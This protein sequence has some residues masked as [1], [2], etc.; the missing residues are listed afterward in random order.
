MTGS[1]NKKAI[2]TKYSHFE[3]VGRLHRFAQD[4]FTVSH[5]IQQGTDR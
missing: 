4:V 2:Y 1:L 3:N 5:Q